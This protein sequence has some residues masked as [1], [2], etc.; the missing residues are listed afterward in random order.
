MT[1][2]EAKEAFGPAYVD[3]AMTERARCTRFVD[4]AIRHHEAEP[5]VVSVLAQLRLR[6]HNHPGGEGLARIDVLVPM[7][8]GSTEP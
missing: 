5:A 4:D 3:G 2:D 8:T 6:I 7:P 1:Q